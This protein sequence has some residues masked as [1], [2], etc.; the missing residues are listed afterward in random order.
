MKYNANSAS[1]SIAATA[2]GRNC[3]RVAG[4]HADLRQ[5]AQAFHAPVRALHP[6]LARRTALAAHQAEGAVASAIAQNG[7]RHGFQEANP[8][9]A[10]VAAAPASG[11]SGP[12]T[13][14]VGLETHG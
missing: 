3:E 13:N 5:C 12:R 6:I 4:L 7:G 9:H 14:D 8:A 11:A 1:A 10:A 2:R